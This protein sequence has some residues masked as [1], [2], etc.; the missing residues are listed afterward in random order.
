MRH[1]MSKEVYYIAS[2]WTCVWSCSILTFW[3]SFFF[4]PWSFDKGFLERWSLP[5][6]RPF[7]CGAWNGTL[8]PSQVLGLAQGPHKKLDESQSEDFGELQQ[9]SQNKKKHLTHNMDPRNNNKS[10]TS[11]LVI[12]CHC[13]ILKPMLRI[14]MP[15]P[16]LSISPVQELDSLQ[17]LQAQGHSLLWPD[18]SPKKD[19]L[20]AGWCPSYVCWFII[21][22][23]PFSYSML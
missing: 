15:H 17:G 6:H 7:S 8:L 3:L 12:A 22:I 9:T 19:V 16:H 5:I 4:S 11:L 18:G 13:S 14:G 23:I 20:H 1:V 10:Q 2:F 21:F